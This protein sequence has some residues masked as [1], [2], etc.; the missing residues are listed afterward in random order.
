MKNWFYIALSFL[1]LT[2]TFQSCKKDKDDDGL[3]AL[4]EQLR[5]KDALI[6]QLE[7]EKNSLDN[8]NKQLDETNKKLDELIK[9]LQGDNPSGEG[10][11]DVQDTS[12]VIVPTGNT[13]ENPGWKSVATAGN[14][15]YTMTVVFELPAELQSKASANDLMAAFVGDECRGV[16]KA[17]DGKFLLSVIGTGE[18]TDNVTFR[19]WNAENHYLYEYLVSVPFSSDRI[20]GVVDNPKK[21]VCKQL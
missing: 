3:E 1:L 17:I 12:A 21:F 14:Y 18:E 20:Y 10:E 16:G 6:K 7:E 8:T 13:F 11:E 15:A 5:Q 2:G 4:E 19:Y 9:K